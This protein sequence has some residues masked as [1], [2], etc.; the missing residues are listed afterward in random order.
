MKATE[1][2]ACEK[3]FFLSGTCLALIDELQFFTMSSSATTL[4]TKLILSVSYLRTPYVYALNYSLGHSLKRRPPQDRQRVLSRRHILLPDAHDS[5]D[6]ANLLIEFEKVTKGIFNFQLRKEA[7]RLWCLCAGLKRE[8]VRLLVLSYRQTRRATRYEVTM[9]DIEKAYMSVEF[10]DSRTDVE[11]VIAGDTTGLKVREDLVCPF[12]IDVSLESRYQTALK[13]ARADQLERAVAL[14]SLTP[15]ERAALESHPKQEGG[16]PGDDNTRRGA[17]PAKPVK[18][19]RPTT[20][21]VFQNAETFWGRSPT[22][23]GR[24]L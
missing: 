5:A 11:L 9:Q 14:A 1:N 4:I 21:E 12:Q 16:I 15:G 18:K 8:L 3:A 7:F 23:K 6:W 22:S 10:S 13:D 24:T 20:A 2:A 19:G 17:P